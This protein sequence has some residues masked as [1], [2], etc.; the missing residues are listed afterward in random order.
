M[1]DE[2]VAVDP[3]I[4]RKRMVYIMTKFMHAMKI[5]DDPSIIFRP[6]MLQK[7]YEMPTK[8]EQKMC[9]TF[10]KENAVLLLAIVKSW[11]LFK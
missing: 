1:Y 5:M 2:Y 7:S 3:N 4:T 10:A 9:E 6:D 11:E 8:N